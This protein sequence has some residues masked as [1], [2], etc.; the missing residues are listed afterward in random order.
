MLL[1]LYIIQL[2]SVLTIVA[3]TLVIAWCLYWLVI[4]IYQTV[5]CE[6]EDHVYMSVIELNCFQLHSKVTTG[7]DTEDSR[8]IQTGIEA[9]LKEDGEYW[10][11]IHRESMICRTVTN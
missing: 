1:I 11:E 3:I 2:Y 5:P 4:K 9:E 6:L 8:S 10:L 7:Q